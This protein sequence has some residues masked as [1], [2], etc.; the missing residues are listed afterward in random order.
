MGDRTVRFDL[1]PPHA[2][3]AK[4]D[5]VLVE[6]FWDDDVIHA[7]LGEEAAPRKICYASEA[8][9]FFIHRAGNLD[10]AVKIRI[11]GHEGIG[12]YDGGGEPA[13]HVAGAAAEHLSIPHHA[14]EGINGPAFA[15]LHHVDM[16]IEMDSGTR[17]T[18]LAPRNHIGARIAVA[19][20]W[21]S[22]AAN[23]T[24]FETA[25]GKNACEMFGAGC[26]GLARR[27][28]RGKADEVNSQRY[29][30]E[31]GRAHV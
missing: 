8:S 24:R 7:G 25:R 28:H 5:A 17:R 1:R 16:G 22:L 12:R 29:E 14:R 6:R 13:L 11:D 2:A 3:M 9:R 15:R 23:Q 26:V 30:F 18:P 10:R 21:R 20:A 27:V 4:T 31:I 19:V